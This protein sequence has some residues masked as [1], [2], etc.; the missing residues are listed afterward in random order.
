MAD[1]VPVSW[2]NGA[3]GGTPLS[4][5]NLN[6]MEDRIE[7]IDE[8]FQMLGG[9]AATF[10]ASIGAN[11]TFLGS[12]GTSP[13]WRTAS[14]VRSD[15]GL[16]IGTNVQAFSAALAGLAAVATAANKLIYATGANTFATTDFTLQARQLLD[17]TS[18]SAMRAT[19][20]LGTMA[21]QAASSVAITGGTI[22]GVSLSAST[23]T[24]TGPATVGGNLSVGGQGYS[25]MVTL[26]DGATVS[27]DGDDGNSFQVTVAGNRTMAAVAHQ[28]AG[29]VYNILIKKSGSGRTITWGSA[30]KFPGGADIQLS[31][32]SNPDLFSFL[33]DGTN[34]Y[35]AGLNLA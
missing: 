8:L 1:Y 5:D 28:Q 7:E 34:L 27:P 21:E 19:L 35:S 3:G 16:V 29:A 4:M 30:Y 26:A 32:G 17:D 22:A 20:G 18:F 11:L 15:L 14:Q 31:G 23:I 33:S 9:T 24:T 2:A 13:L 12:D 25:P 6:T 10:A